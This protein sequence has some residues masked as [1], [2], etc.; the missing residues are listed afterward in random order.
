M[1]IHLTTNNFKKTYG[2]KD[3]VLDQI[4]VF[5]YKIVSGSN[6]EKKG[7]TN[8][9][10]EREAGE[11]PGKYRITSISCDQY[12]KLKLDEESAYFTIEKKSIGS[13]Y[14]GKMQIPDNGKEQTADVAALYYSERREKTNKDYFKRIHPMKKKRNSRSFRTVDEAGMIHFT[15][16]QL[17]NGA[18]VTIPFT[19]EGEYVPAIRSRYP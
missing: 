15:L 1:T 18:T 19:A 5:Q 17:G 3:P 2:E 4:P 16:K 6:V 14:G 10:Y 9:V 11:K 7:L 8:I 12:R 13:I